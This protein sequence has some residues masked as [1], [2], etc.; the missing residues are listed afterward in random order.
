MNEIKKYAVL[1]IALSVL[2]V[3]KFVYV[4]IIDWQNDLY[5]QIKQQENKLNK[6]N[7]VL[8]Q[9][10]SVIQ[11]NALLETLLTKTTSIFFLQSEEAK[12]QLK[13]QKMLESL[14]EKYNLKSTK[15]AW[16]RT[17]KLTALTV[18]HY[19]LQ[20]SLKGRTNKL[21]QLMSVIESHTPY[22]EISDF[23]LNVKRQKDLSLG[24][25]TGNITLH[26]YMNVTED[27]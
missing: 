2:V 15:F 24:N 22:I 9:K 21:V 13:Q 25:V 23:A 18:Q 12:F 4:P 3:V 20:I 19:K 26:L 5:L 17:Q 7:K 1:L 6:I 14:F 8:S 16:K 27:S 11:A 10:E